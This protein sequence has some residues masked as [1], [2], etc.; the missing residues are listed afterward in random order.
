MALFGANDDFTFFALRIDMPHRN[1]FKVVEYCF[2]IGLLCIQFHVINWFFSCYSE[3]N[4]LF[5]K[6]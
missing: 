2:Y 1:K 6:C 3:I 5:K 4:K